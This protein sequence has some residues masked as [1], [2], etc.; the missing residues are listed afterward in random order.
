MTTNVEVYDGDFLRQFQA[1]PNT[2]FCDVCIIH[3][4]RTDRTDFCRYIKTNIHLAT[5]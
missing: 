2:K 1:E 4:N 3:F 5:L